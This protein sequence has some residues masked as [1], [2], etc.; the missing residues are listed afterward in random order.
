MSKASLKLLDVLFRAA[1]FT[2]AVAVNGAP[3]VRAALSVKDAA[4]AIA[5]PA[6]NIRQQLLDRSPCL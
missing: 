1:A 3:S 2:I 6:A 4:A 5:W